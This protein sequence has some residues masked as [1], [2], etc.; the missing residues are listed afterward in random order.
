MQDGNDP[1]VAL[2]EHA[3]DNFNKSTVPGSFLVDFFPIL[4]SLPEWLP[5]MEFMETA[6][7]WKKDTIEMVEA[8]YKFTLQQM[9]RYLECSCY[10]D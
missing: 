4:R 3:N 5:G 8:P 2:I 10:V 9:V 7:R 1:Y 6:R